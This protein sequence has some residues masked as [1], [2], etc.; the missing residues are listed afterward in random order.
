MSF[1]EIGLSRPEGTLPLRVFRPRTK[2]RGGVIFYMDAFGWRDEIDRMCARYAEH[3]YVCYLPDLYWRLGTLRFRPHRSRDEPLPAGM[4]AAN[5][6]TTVEMSI[7]DTGAILEQA[8]ADGVARLGTVGHCMGA[9]HALGALATYP[10]KI[11][12]A[13]CLHGGRLVWDGPSSPH[14]YILRV[15]GPVY[16]AFAADDPTCPDAHKVLIE[17]AARSAG[18]PVETEHFAAAHGWTFPERWCYDR[19]AA[20]RAWGKVN[21]LFDRHVATH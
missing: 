15:R 9:R 19:V 6:A 11:G 7:A 16:F 17:D 3:G 8:R 13:A 20:E 1:T 2:P 18:A 4:D 21:S 10:G 12:A 14:L 5:S